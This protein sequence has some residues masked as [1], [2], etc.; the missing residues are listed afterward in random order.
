MEPKKIKLCSMGFAL[1][2]TIIIAMDIA[3][4][5]GVS[6]ESATGFHRFLNNAVGIP[7]VILMA[8]GMF[9]VTGVILINCINRWGLLIGLFVGCVTILFL[10]IVY[11]MGLTE[12]QQDKAAIVLAILA[13]VYG[14]VSSVLTIRAYI[15]DFKCEKLVSQ[16]YDEQFKKT[17]DSE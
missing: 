10:A 5:G 14:I 12:K 1:F 8:Y 6:T 2:F 11:C 16:A 15:L 4:K 17:T 9:F 3:K 13:I 7:L